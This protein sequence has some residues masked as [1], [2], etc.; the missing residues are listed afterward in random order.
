M[1]VI[2]AILCFVLSACTIS[3]QPLPKKTTK[4]HATRHHATTKVSKKEHSTNS[5]LVKVDHAWV[6]RY[7]ELED[8]FKYWIAEDDEIKAEDEHF[9][10]PKSVVEHDED[11]LRAKLPTPTP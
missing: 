11:M 5:N 6:T 9:L 2:V 4:S 1:K 8:K 10:V 7:K 3:V